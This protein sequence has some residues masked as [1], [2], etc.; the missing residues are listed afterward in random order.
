MAFGF[1]LTSSDCT[2]AAGNV[3]SEEDYYVEGPCQAP[4]PPLFIHCNWWKYLPKLP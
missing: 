4:I 2:W 1:A 3:N